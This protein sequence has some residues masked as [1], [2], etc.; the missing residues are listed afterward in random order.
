MRPAGAE[1][2]VHADQAAFRYSWRSPPSRSYRCPFR[3]VS[4]SGSVSG[5]GSGCRGAGVGDAAVRAVRVVVAFVLAQ[6]VQQVCLV[7]D[8]P[9]AGA[10]TLKGHAL[11]PRARRSEFRF[12]AEAPGQ[13]TR[14]HPQQ[15]EGVRLVSSAPE[16]IPDEDHEQVIERVCAIDVA[17]AC[18]APPR[19]GG[20]T[21]AVGSRTTRS[22][23]GT[24]SRASAPAGS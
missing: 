19:R 5:S 18:S 16:E 22:W 12:P 17:R 21:G 1:K 8:E 10:P 14:R 24:R 6:G 3:R 9:G 2:A 20:W 11:L 7:P 13:P 15:E 23:A 4:S